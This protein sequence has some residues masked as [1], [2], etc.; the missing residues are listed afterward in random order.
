M[1][2][3]RSLSLFSMRNYLC[4]VFRCGL[5]GHGEA[6]CLSDGSHLRPDP[7]APLRPLNLGLVLEDFGM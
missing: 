4:S 1:V 2:S 6:D 3:S 7:Q 5:V